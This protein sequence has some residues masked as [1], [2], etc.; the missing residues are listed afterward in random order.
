MDEMG[1]EASRLLQWMLEVAEARN[2]D[3]RAKTVT[4][5]FSRATLTMWQTRVREA[6]GKR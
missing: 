6:L 4:L 2:N 5:K 3:P 1:I